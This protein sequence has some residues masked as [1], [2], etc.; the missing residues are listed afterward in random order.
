MLAAVSISTRLSRPA[1]D[2]LPAD[3]VAVD[4]G[5]VP[6]EHDDVVAGDG[7]VLERVGAVQDDV[8]GHAL[9]AQ[10]GPD[11]PGQDLEVLDDKHPHEVLRA[12]ASTPAVGVSPVS[13]AD[14]G[15]TPAPPA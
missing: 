14:T 1:G 10:P 6:V 8:D 13:A 5:Q 3:V 7:E 12:M 9:A 2:D 15:L 11:R 4:A